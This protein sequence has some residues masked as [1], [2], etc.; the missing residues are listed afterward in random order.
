MCHV[1][2]CILAGMIVNGDDLL[3]KRIGIKL[4]IHGT[5][6]WDDFQDIKIINFL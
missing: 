2:Q 1:E 6:I 4:H 3:K 5:S